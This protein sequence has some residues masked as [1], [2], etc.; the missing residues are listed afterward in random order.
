MTT[1]P[2]GNPKP[3]ATAEQRIVVGV[4]D[5]AVVKDPGKAIVTYALGSCIGVTIFDPV[6]KVGGMLHFML[7]EGKTSPEKAA[8]NPAMFADSGV[9]LLFQK[10]YKL[11][12][13]RSRLVVCA[14]GG[15]E[16]LAEDGHF[17]IGARNRTMLRKLFWQ[18]NIL[19]AADDTGGS[20]SRTLSLSLTDGTISIRSQG[21][22]S[23][24]WAPAA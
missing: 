19:L 20:H 24:L 16:I 1:T 23:V 2:P 22:E 9:P 8:A 4:A 12:A 17:R 6:T 13:D 7:P 14:A 5:L 21:K 15:A 10:A 3:L 18:N 11:G